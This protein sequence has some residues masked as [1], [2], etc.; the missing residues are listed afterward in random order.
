MYQLQDQ[1]KTII[2]NWNK[3]QK[4]NTE[5]QLVSVQN[6]HD[7]SLEQFCDLLEKNISSIQII[8]VQ[9]ED[10]HLPVIKVSDNIF[11]SAIPLGKELEPFLEALSFANSSALPVLSEATQ[12][13]L[14]KIVIPVE[15]KLYIAQQCP[16]CPKMVSSILPLAVA[17]KNIKLKIVDGT[18]F[19][20]EAQKDNVMSAPCLILDNNFRWTG[21]VTPEEITDMIVNQT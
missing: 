12:A 1:E 10:G 7:K 2:L 6:E 14:L 11:Y 20:Q 16:H 17:C 3:I 18:L 8:K 15:L 13:N 19:T 9:S 5:I 21:S 4:Q